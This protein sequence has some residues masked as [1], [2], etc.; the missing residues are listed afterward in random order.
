MKFPF[1]RSNKD[2]KR[3]IKFTSGD[4]ERALGSV[5]SICKQ[6]HTVVLNDPDHPDG[7]YILNLQSGE[8]MALQHEDGGFVLDT[9]VAPSGTQA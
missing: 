8:R 1:Q 9:K 2:E 3:N 7:S 6:G 5:S 4:V